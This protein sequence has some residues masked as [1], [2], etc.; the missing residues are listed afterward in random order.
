MTITIALLSL[1]FSCNDL[2]P[3]SFSHPS[4]PSLPKFRIKSK[5]PFQTFRLLVCQFLVLLSFLSFSH[6][7]FQSI[8][9]AKG[10]PRQWKH[11]EIFDFDILFFSYVFADCFLFVV[12]VCSDKRDVIAVQHRFVLLFV[13]VNC[14]HRI[15]SVLL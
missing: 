4:F 10:I 2:Q 12:L 7:T 5:E 14:V 15:R 1:L 6:K 13:S 9:S 11:F 3:T 8:S